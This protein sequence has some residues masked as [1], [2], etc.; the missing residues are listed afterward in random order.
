VVSGELKKSKKTILVT[1]S[2]AAVS[3]IAALGALLY[4]WYPTTPIYSLSKASTAIKA[5]DWKTFSRYV[6]M[7]KL[8]MEL[9]KEITFIAYQKMDEKGIPSYVSKNLAVRYG[10]MVKKNLPGDIEAWV[11]N[12][13]PPAASVLSSLAKGSSPGKFKLQGI[14]WKDGIA[15]AKVSI[16]K[17]GILEIELTR[18]QGSWRITQINNVIELYE[19]SKG[20]P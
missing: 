13:E 17:T 12:G 8:S 4:F 1:L 10:T 9:A 15:H 11:R 14:S 16:G 3:I 6:D 19:K 20:K 2:I 18:E 5:H 7:E